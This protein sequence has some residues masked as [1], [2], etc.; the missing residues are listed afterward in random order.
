M[1][2]R[3]TMIALA[4][5]GLLSAAALA[6]ADGPLL[7]EF[8]P[9]LSAN[10]GALVISSGG[11]TPD[12]IISQGEVLPQPEGGALNRAEEAPMVAEPGDSVRSE[13]AGRRSESFRPDRTTELNGTVGYYTVFTPT[14]APFKRVTALDAVTLSRGTPILGGADRRGAAIEVVGVHATPPDPRPRDQFWGN[15]V[16]DFSEGRT[17]PFPSVA[18]DARLL[19]VDAEP[20]VEL[21]FSKDSADNFYATVEGEAPRYVR[22]VF[23]TDA[24]RTYFGQPI[25]DGPVDAHAGRMPPLPASVQRDADIFASELGLSRDSEFRDALVELTAHFRS[26]EESREPPAD[27]GNIY[28]DL[29]RGQRG[30]C[31]HRA[32]G[33]VIT[34]I[35]LGMHAR[36]VQNE[37]HAWAEVELPGTAGWLRV[38]LGGAATGLEARG[39]EDRP[40]HRPDV[41]DPLPRPEEYEAAYEEAARMSGLRAPDP[42]EA[43]AGGASGEATSGAE[44]GGAAGAAGEAGEGGE[45]TATAPTATPT[46]GAA[47]ESASRR[48][49]AL[50]VD[51]RAF[52]VFRGRELEV[53]GGARAGGGAVP[54]L[55][56]EALLR[57]PRG[58]AEWLLGV[59]VTDANG[60]YRGVFGVPPDLPVGDYELVVRS[61]GSREVSAAVAR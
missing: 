31:R 55:R 61:P 35:G 20:A 41:T 3:A 19:T 47:A 27:T 23:L 1:R 50:T 39:A 14:I 4:L 9:D 11:A 28:L 56:V 21:R 57:A 18:P 60:R 51:R 53:T 24:P 7:H 5:A 44:G 29:S 43:G 25:P 32:Y 33:F 59:T 15:V 42:E 13:E 2:R 49:L 36:F 16:L 46:Q 38:D 22:V 48:P 40:V 12:A 6:L 30:I 37:A 45:A 26:F 8:V 34:A 58:E 17:V 10:E 52:E 54:G